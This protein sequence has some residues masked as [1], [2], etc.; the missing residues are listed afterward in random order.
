MGQGGRILTS[1]VICQHDQVRTSGSSPR[2]LQP[3]R[4]PASPASRSSG[5]IQ[6]S[7]SRVHPTDAGE[8]AQGTRAG[9]FVLHN[10]P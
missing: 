2:V 9:R 8:V 6:D 1:E 10:L 7:L 4:L 5:T 3:A